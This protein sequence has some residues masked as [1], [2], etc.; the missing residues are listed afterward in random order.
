[1]QIADIVLVAG[2]TG[3]NVYYTVC[4]ERSH[5][6]RYLHFFVF[7]RLLRVVR[8]VQALAECQNRDLTDLLKDTQRFKEVSDNK[9]EILLLK[10]EDCRV[11]HSTY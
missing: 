11:F 1:M 7:I 5:R 4:L 2:V 3:F 10:L 8:V 9:A 6:G